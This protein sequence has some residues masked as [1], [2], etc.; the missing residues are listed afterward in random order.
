[1]NGNTRS[2][3][4][5]LLKHEL[6]A[7]QVGG[8]AFVL[9]LT[10]F[11]GPWV[12]LNILMSALGYDLTAFYPGMLGMLL[13][14]WLMG[15]CALTTY[16][17]VPL[18][19]SN[20]TSFNQFEF[21]FTRAIDRRLNFRAKAAAALIIVLAPQLPG[22]VC[23]L[24]Q[25]DMVVTL[26][27]RAGETEVQRDNLEGRAFPTERYFQAF[28]GSA[29]LPAPKPEEHERLRIR[30]GWFTYNCWLAWAT[31]L[32][33]ALFFAYYALVG[34]HLRSSGWWANTV[35]IAPV[36]LV[37]GAILF[38][39]WRGFNPGDELFLFF[40]THWVL[41][42]LVLAGACYASLRWCERR[43]AALQIV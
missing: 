22:L 18:V 9:A 29:R 19:W 13:L 2:P 32:L 33:T 41:C 14:F 21:Q 4:L 30:H 15:A 35:L 42:A 17:Q 25:S 11:Y 20:T 7:G 39:I 31:T 26:D 3:F 5:V 23:S 1:M 40:R 28:P 6:G 24:V 43:F 8:L 37:I 12:A 34:P 10:F 16:P 36:P 38:A 27:A